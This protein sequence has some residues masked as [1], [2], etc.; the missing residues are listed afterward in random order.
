MEA[1]IGISAARWGV[2]RAL[3][4]ILDGL[5]EPWAAS[6]ALGTKIH[7]LKMELLYAQG[8]LDNARGRDVRSAA[9]GQLLLELRRL[10]YAADDA[11]DDLE[12]FRIQD[13]LYGTKK[14]TD[15]DDQGCLKGLVVNAHHT[16]KTHAGKLSKLLSYPCTAC[17]DDSDEEQEDGSGGC[18]PRACSRYWENAQAANGGCVPKVVS[19]ARAIGKRL[20]CTRTEHAPLLK[21]DRVEMSERMSKILDELKPVCAKVSTILGLELSGMN[22]T[23]TKETPLDRPETTHHIIQ[24]KLYGRGSQIDHVV[25][26]IT[27]SKYSTNNLTVLSFYGQGG[28]GKTTFAQHIYDKA[29]SNFQIHLWICVSHGSNANMLARDIAKQ[30]QSSSDKKGSAAPSGASDKKGSAAPSGASDKKDSAEDQIEM[31]V[32]SKRFL[33][34]LD[35]MWTYHED[36]WNK[37]LAPFRKAGPAGN[38]VIVTTRFPG[39]AQSVATTV[40]CSTKLDR[41]DYKDSMA[42]FKACIFGDDE[43]QWEGHDN[44]LKVGSEI[45]PKLKGSPLAVKTVGR[46][47]RTKLHTDHWNSILDSKEWELQT[48][49]EDVMPALQL[50]YNYLPFEAQQ[51]FYHC[52]LFREDYKF[53]GQELIHMW[54]GLGLLGNSN[55]NKRIEDI[56]QTYL[57]I[58]VDHG[59][60]EI[61][62]KE[63][64][65]PYY[66]IHDLLHELAVKV[67]SFE[68]LSIH[69]SNIRSTK[70]LASIR[71]LSITIDNTVVTDRKSFEKFR[72]DL[73]ALGKRLK[74][75]NL[76]TLMLFGV[77]HGSFLKTLR[78]MF[79]KAKSLRVVYLSEA[80]YNLNNLFHDFSN[81]VRLRYLRIE[82]VRY[83]TPTSLPNSISRFYHLIVLHAHVWLKKFPQ[84]VSNLVKLRHFVVGDNGEVHSRIPMV[85]KLHALQELKRFEVKRETN[86][87]GLEQLGP[88]ELRGSLRIDNLENIQ[89]V[90]EADEA[91]LAHRKHLHELTL[92][93]SEIS[94]QKALTRA[95]KE[96]LVLQSLKPHSNI[97]ALRISGNGGATCPEWLGVE[98]D[99]EHLHLERVSWGTLP[100]LG[101]TCMV[102]EH[103]KE[104]VGCVPGQGFKN[105]KTL[106]LVGIE[107]LIKWR[108]NGTC[109]LLSHLEELTVHRCYLLKELP[110][111][112][113]SCHESE[114]EENM[115]A[116]FPKLRT[117]N[118]SNCHNL[119]P[120][121]SLPWT[122][123]VCFIKIKDAGSDFS[124]LFYT[125]EAN[126]SIILRISGRDQ[127]NGSGDSTFWDVLD[128]SN[129][130]ELE[131][132]TISSCPPLPL[133]RLQALKSL[134]KLCIE[135]SSSNV[136]LSVEERSCVQCYVSVTELKIGNC[137]SSGKELTKMLS[138]FPY[139]SRLYLHMHSRN[140]F[141]GLGVAE[142]EQH[143]NVAVRDEA[144]I[145]A[146][147][148]TLL[149][150]PQIEFL[151]ILDCQ[152]L[153]DCS[154]SATGLQN[155]R[156]LR[157]LN[158]SQLHMLGSSVLSPSLLFPT[159]LQTLTLWRV[160]TSLTLP[161]L[162]NLTELTIHG[163]SDVRGKDLLHLLPQLTDL[164][165]EE[166]EK[167][168]DGLDPSRTLSGIRSI[169]TCDVEGL[170]VS[171]ICSI[172]SS[173]LA[174][175]ILLGRKNYN[176]QRL[177]KD[178]EKALL[179]L[180]SLLKLEIISFCN[181]QSAPGGLSGHPSLKLL[182][183]STCRNLQS[184]PKDSL[185]A[186]LEELVIWDCPRL[187]SLPKE[188]L[189]NSLR[190]VSA[191]GTEIHPELIRHCRKLQGTIPIVEI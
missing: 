64:K 121:P 157:T 44:L 137:G 2:T 9:L 188:G 139:L 182:R 171:P 112:R 21:F 20:P 60:F 125:K 50:S 90:E 166:I 88:L 48:N 17:H 73:S 102:Y 43:K 106:S 89:S 82:G 26:D 14:A 30:I 160:P 22:R 66:V 104:C 39:L 84:D 10:A 131:D 148:F 136:L 49:N 97:R 175:L 58:L 128:F 11:L 177:T 135:N 144:E 191:R 189:P 134:K 158:V 91:K 5:L 96:E 4:P 1:T 6:S 110:F 78:D 119:L 123:A 154:M 83:S 141:S 164:H 159:S 100:L 143:V 47:L 115:L 162:P 19:C 52:V 178:Q 180:T 127:G 169:C 118:I 16:V 77:Y 38:I 168:F 32:Q 55:Q 185:P 190:R 183:F 81:L 57:D 113:S 80:T 71:H 146:D 35:D 132:W 75:E 101:K 25:K 85:G 93:W 23:T 37:L 111:S 36:E 42:L 186:S 46:L 62:E 167:F 72:I 7:E 117:L 152:Q 105:L 155:M 153:S 63:G 161:P 103:G 59:F 99:L 108:G 28:I 150:P 145:T 54:I 156:S 8:M 18:L 31:A 114:R 133:D 67:S 129:L 94:T 76:H 151:Q 95:N 40:D 120:L 116:V 68:C 184:L 86:G 56:G 69:S 27:G 107:E 170:L 79:K 176:L 98:L 147:D 29:K 92:N 53:T 13:E 179:M 12:Y 15:D 142:P 34:V 61:G 70:I 87:F 51:C 187:R 181:L 122:S 130:T 174:N 173:S 74:A 140:G 124:E 126:E 109:H 3:G 165:I 24:P 163:S 138:H 149:L 33:L 41:L 45:V 172:I 65:L